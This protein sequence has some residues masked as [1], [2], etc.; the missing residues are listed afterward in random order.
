MN[1]IVMKLKI[2]KERDSDQ[3]SKKSLTT[4]GTP[5]MESINFFAG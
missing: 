1:G 2:R 5:G 4:A 3:L